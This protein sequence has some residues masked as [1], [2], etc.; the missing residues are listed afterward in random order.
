MSNQTGQ[1]R[2]F[3]RA[4][5]LIRNSIIAVA[6]ST[7]SLLHLDRSIGFKTKATLYAKQ[8]GESNVVTVELLKQEITLS[9]ARYIIEERH[10]AVVSGREHISSA[11]HQFAVEVSYMSTDSLRVQSPVL[12]LEYSR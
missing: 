8:S 2:I 7:D 4:L 11:L 5:S 12:S 9:D 1:S 6:D 3:A 10:Y